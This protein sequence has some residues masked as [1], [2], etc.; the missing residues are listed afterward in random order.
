MGVLNCHSSR[1][2]RN[3][4]AQMSTKIYTCFSETASPR[5]PLAGQ[6]QP[7]PYVFFTPSSY[8][9]LRMNRPQWAWIVESTAEM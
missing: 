5:L 3:M 7:S 2:K 8:I 9:N 1:D 6:S 4:P